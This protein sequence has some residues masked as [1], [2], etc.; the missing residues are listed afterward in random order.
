MVAKKTK[1]ITKKTTRKKTQSQTRRHWC[2]PWGLLA[3]V[4]FFSSLLLMVYVFYLDVQIKQELDNKSWSAPSRVFAR[5]QE[6]FMG[7][8]LSIAQLTEE[9]R[10]LGYQPQRT[11]AQEGSFYRKKNLFRIHV[12]AFDFWDGRVDARKI[13]LRFVKGMITQLVNAETREE[14]DIVRLEPVYIGGLYPTSKKDRVLVALADVPPKL[15]EILLAVE[16][17]HFYQH[18][19]LQFKS[20]LRAL[21]ANIQAG[22][23]VQGGSTITQ[24]LVKNLFLTQERSLLRKINEAIMALLV[25]LHYTKAQILE[26]YINETYL[27]QDGSIAIHGFGLASYFYFAESLDSLSIDEMALLV[28][29]IQGPSAL[30]PRKHADR[31]KKRR[32]VVLDILVQANVLSEQKV[33]S[34]K[35]TSLKI[36]RDKPQGKTPYPAFLDLV[37][38]QLVNDYQAG[39]LTSGG[40][41]IFTTLDLISQRVAEK[42][43]ISRV[44]ALEKQT[45]LKSGTLQ[46]ATI[47]SDSATGEIV[48]LVGGRR[49][50]YAGFNRALDARR[51][52]G[53]LIKPVVYL[54]A[55]NDP[56]YYHLATLLED[57]PISITGSRGTVWSPQNYDKKYQNEI[58]LYE[59]L[60]QSR[61]IP[62]VNLGMQIGLDKVIDTLENLGISQALEAY[63]S[64][65]LGAV[66][67]TLFELSQ[68]YQTFASEGF[69]TPLR[70]IRAVTTA[71]GKTLQ[72]YPLTVQQKFDAEPI[73]LL[74]TALQHVVQHG[75]AQSLSQWLPKTL[76]IAGKTGTSDDMKDSWFAGFSGDRVAVVWMG[77]DDNNNVDLTG[78]SGAL[79]VWGSIFAKLS[80]RP[81]ELV[82]P[83]NIVYHKIEGDSGLLG[84]DECRVVVVLPFMVHSGPT[85]FASCATGIE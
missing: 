27:G 63:P 39:D 40:L 10:Q 20:V 23:T 30:N 85:E 57:K 1:K 59:A 4:I 29:I 80:P 32:D 33:Q 60:A 44:D 71:Q 31:V 5:P 70:S 79:T 19:G 2:F 58:L 47:I 36:L 50:K 35:Q 24:Q 6:L 72:R 64:L 28:G 82:Q 83:P 18:H 46:A 73:F 7:R 62:T 8:S 52:I 69:Q 51:P 61:N 54:A 81:L 16:D 77:A 15:I 12:R 84:G 34:L 45:G 66:E 17:R 38:R 65:L 42:S 37:K 11:I 22:R 25:E 26:L 56:E 74:N 53:S 13:E 75:T 9:L 48:T 14:L 67:L 55:L 3:Q 68:M 78:A 43:V 76:N 21:L 49:P 41:H